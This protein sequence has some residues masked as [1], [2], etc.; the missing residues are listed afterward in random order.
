MFCV[1]VATCLAIIGFADIRIIE[2][3]D[4]KHRDRSLEMRVTAENIVRR[5]KV[6]QTI[7]M[8]PSSNGTRAAGTIGYNKSADYVYNTVAALPGWT[9]QRCARALPQHLPVTD[10]PAG[11][12]S[13]SCQTCPVHQPSSRCVVLSPHNHPCLLILTFHPRWSCS[14]APRVDTALH[15]K[16]PRHKLH[17]PRRPQLPS[18][19]LVCYRPNAFHPTCGVFHSWLLRFDTV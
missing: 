18:I 7:A 10:E 17:G 9:V 15:R 16:C 3:E 2:P 5:L 19:C 8:L 12:A 11:S 1:I 13:H 6:L 14:F 4:N